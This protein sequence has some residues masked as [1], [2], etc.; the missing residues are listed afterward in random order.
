MYK[1]TLQWYSHIMFYFWRTNTKFSFQ[2]LLQISLF[3]MFST[4][5]KITAKCSTVTITM[6]TGTTPIGDSTEDAKMHLG[7]T[8]N[9]DQSSFIAKY[10]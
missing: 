7:I 2:A 9:A 5:I 1:T 4:S 6:P 3:D 8:R 10:F